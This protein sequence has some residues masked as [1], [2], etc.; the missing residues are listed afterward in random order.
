MH[1]LRNRAVLAGV[2]AVSKIISQTLVM[3]SSVNFR[4]WL[5]SLLSFSFRAASFSGD[6]RFLV[7]PWDIL[8]ARRPF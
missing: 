1:L 2:L 4:Y 3:T 8:E 5:I 7:T 6:S